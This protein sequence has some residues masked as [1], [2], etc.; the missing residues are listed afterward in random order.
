MRKTFFYL[1]LLLFQVCGPLAAQKISFREKY[2]PL[3]DSLSSVYQIPAS[4]ILGVAIIESGSGTS[5]NS[6]L[7]KN[8][9]GIKG[10]N[11]LL[12]TKGIRSSYKQ[13]KT[14]TAS[15]IDFCKLVA[16]KQFYSKLAGNPDYRPWIEALS[17]TGYSEVP[18]TWRNLIMNAIKKNRLDKVDRKENSE[19]PAESG[20]RNI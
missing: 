2:Q 1:L 19:L 10:R 5:R 20:N 15:F 17:K 6:K 16:K 11:N 18:A 3:A 13:Y 9:F 4:V 14:D 12:K 7:L 8:F